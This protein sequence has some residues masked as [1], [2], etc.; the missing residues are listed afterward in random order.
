MI[1]NLKPDNIDFKALVT[2]NN[3]K[4]TLNCQTKMITELQNSFTEDEQK[5]YIANFYIYLHYHPTN[6]YPIN[7]ENV[8]KILGFA[9]KGNAKRVLENNFVVDEDYKILLIRK[10]N[11]VHGGHNIEDV[12]LNI[13]TF[14]NLCM[15]IKTNKGKEIRKY[16]VKLENIFNKVVNEERVEYE[17]RV[18]ELEDKV[19]EKD[20]QLVKTIEQLESTTKLTVKKWYDQEPGHTIYGYKNLNNNLITIGK[21]KNIKRR[22]G[23]YLTHNPDGNM[24]YIRKCYNCDLAEKVI[25]HI[26]DKYREERNK[27]WF[28]LNETLTTYVIDTVCDFLDNFINCSEKLPEFKI[29]EFI[30]N[31][32]IQ[33][34]D[35]I[36]EPS[37]LENVTLSFNPN[38]K[39]YTQFINDYCIIDESKES[40]TLTYDLRSAYKIWCKKSLQPDIYNE[41]S[42]YIEENFEIKTKYFN[43]DGI[44]HKI[45]TNLKL[46]KL[47]FIVDDKYNI[48][49][50]EN[51][52]LEC[53]V[54][55]YAYKIKI[56][57][58]LTNYTKWMQEKYVDYNITPKDITEIKNYFNVKFMVDHSYICGIQ[59]KTDELPDCRIRDFT[60]ILMINENKEI[61]NTFNGLSEAS[62]KLNL[63][64]K[65]ISDIIRYMKVLSINVDDTNNI[66]QKVTLVYNKDESIITK[67]KVKS[68]PIYKYNFETKELLHTF[69][70]TI[71][72]AQKFNITTSTVLK[73]IGTEYIFSCKD[74]P[75]INI[76]LSYLDNIDDLILKEKTKVVKSR[77]RKPLFTYFHNTTT[78]YKEYEG[79]SNAAFE[80]KIGQC[81]VQRHIKNKTPLSIV[82]NDFVISIIFTY[83]KL[84]LTL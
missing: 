27:E 53:C 54:I 12:M 16:Y 56:D 6:E 77:K 74:N 71:E 68:K 17:R 43:N 67:R 72:A 5:W 50:Y 51:F 44:R 9:T 80:L 42:K 60:K 38:I 39:N 36:I 37:N 66:E 1:S 79:P 76:L 29:K 61:I 55:D 63:E 40:T 33:K 64:I 28:Q 4:M 75:K 48:K 11:Q 83:E 31:L 2:T 13:D 47:E 81:T 19:E 69:E 45:I 78:L 8:Y 24:F 73:Y 57:D 10:D 30:S 32:P 70:S 34:Y 26:L 14:K 41:F 21:S 65:T 82:E 59:L 18:K 25:H 52:C 35:N 7:L 46:K 84:V 58:F 15:L 62:D 3:N 23:G 49:T 20:K 22:E